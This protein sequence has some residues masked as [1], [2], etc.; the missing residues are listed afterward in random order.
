MGADLGAAAALMALAIIGGLVT[1]IRWQRRRA[2][3]DQLA[4]A[5]ERHQ[6]RMAVSMVRQGRAAELNDQERALARAWYLEQWVKYGNESDKQ[7]LIELQ[8]RAG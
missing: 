7:R 3:E 2:F 5:A 1:L 4:R 6:T 8:E